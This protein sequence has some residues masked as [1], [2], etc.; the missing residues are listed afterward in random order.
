MEL[1]RP[2]VAAS[3]VSVLGLG[4]MGAVVAERLLR[5]GKAVSVWNR[6]A[7]KGQG[8]AALGA[9][10][11][12]SAQGAILASPVTLLVLLSTAAARETLAM[13][14]Q[15]LRGKTVVNY[16]SGQETEVEA[17]QSLVHGAGGR[18]LNGSILAYP[19]NIGRRETCFVYSGDL[20]ALEANR[21]L[22]SELAGSSIHLSPPE[23]RAFVAAF[24][25]QIY[26]AL[27]GFYEA[28]TVGRRL[29][30][31]ASTIAAT[32]TDAPRFFFSDAVQ[33]A[34]GRFERGDFS[35][36]QATLDT[37][38]WGFKDLAAS[39]DAQ[40]A[41]TP[42]F[43]L[44]LAKMERARSEGLGGEDISALVKV[45]GALGRPV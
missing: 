14:P 43:D 28:V 1:D 10:R 3:D 5:A 29:G 7:D 37:H 38:Y 41:A 13:A 25:V 22:L 39:L 23:A 16:S 42:F 32:L 2:E 31:E 17:L 26:V 8:L 20:D 6:S 40:G 44:L 30:L 34:A 19:R 35:G 9:R 18:F 21:S 24:Y 12:S 33:D 4:A 36:D 45:N 15:A 27:A 11:S